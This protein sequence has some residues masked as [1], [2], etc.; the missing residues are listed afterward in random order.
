MELVI[1]LQLW[2]SLTLIAGQ[3]LKKR[4]RKIS[5]QELPT[6]IS[7]SCKLVI[8]SLPSSVYP[9]VIHL[10]I[11]P[12]IY[13]HP[14][15]RPLIYLIIE[16]PRRRICNFPL[17]FFSKTQGAQPLTARTR[18]TVKQCKEILSKS[19]IEFRHPPTR[20]K[21]GRRI[22][23]TKITN[24]YVIKRFLFNHTDSNT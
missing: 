15:I 9:S 12:S 20:K 13:I 10:S 18:T 19:N 24:S 1:R 22:I 14:S 21:S 16:A 8:Y 4:N 5:N 17:P 7:G 2:H 23:S 3:T 6:F 11:H